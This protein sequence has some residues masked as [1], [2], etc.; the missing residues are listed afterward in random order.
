MDLSTCQPLKA[1]ARIPEM[2]VGGRIFKTA[3]LRHEWFEYLESPI[4]VVDSLR[5]DDAI[6]DVFTFLQ[7]AHH[8]RPALPY[9]CEPASASVLTFD[10]YDEWWTNLHFKVRN[11]VRKVQKTG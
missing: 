1:P 11:K 8:P 10:S 3:R 9:Y 6:A 7:E 5:R 4:Q 2:A